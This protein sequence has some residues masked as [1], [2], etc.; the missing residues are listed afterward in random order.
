MVRQRMIASA[1][2]ACAILTSN[3]VTVFARDESKPYRCIAKDAVSVL[4]DG[5]LNKSVG[6]V[7]LKLFDKMVID[8]TTGHVSFP[9][10]ATR[11]EWTVEKTSLNDNDYVLFPSAARRIGKSVRANSVTRYIRLRVAANDP[12]PRFVAVTL[13]YLVTGT[14]EVAK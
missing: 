8:V 10:A 5:T 4:Q 7:A 13:S 14:C 6:D 1:L 3:P 11:E 2:F 12:Q 9:N